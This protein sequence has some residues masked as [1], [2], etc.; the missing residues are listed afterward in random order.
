M[1]RWLLPPA[2]EGHGDVPADLWP[3]SCGTP[4]PEKFLRVPGPRLSGAR[5]R[6]NCFFHHRPTAASRMTVDCRMWN[7][8]PRHQAARCW[9]SACSSVWDAAVCGA[10]CG[11]SARRSGG[12]E[13]LTDRSQ[14]AAVC[15]KT[16]NAAGLPNFYFF[17]FLYFFFLVRCARAAHVQDYSGIE[18]YPLRVVM[19][20][21]RKRRKPVQ[22]AWVPREAVWST[23]AGPS[24]CRARE[25]SA[26]SKAE[27]FTVTFARTD[28]GLR[29]RARPSSDQ[30]ENENCLVKNKKKSFERFWRRFL[31]KPLAIFLRLLWPFYIK[32][33]YSIK[34]L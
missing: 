8:R 13:P 23:H 1:S 19:Y 16:A 2:G 29:A 4:P 24:T 33:D 3:T 28:A 14:E 12:A 6:K 10:D 20:A 26:P 5:P 27:R 21:G 18:D 25:R 32:H 7:A 34:W 31:N 11:S 9:R 17:V 22:R 30:T 15:G